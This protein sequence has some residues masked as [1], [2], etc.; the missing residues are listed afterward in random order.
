MPPAEVLPPIDTARGTPATF[1][2]ASV[3][4]DLGNLIQLAY[5]AINV[6]ARTPEMPAIDAASILQRAR[7]SL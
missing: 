3:V 5:S 7:T 6:L 2:A 4:H 1:A